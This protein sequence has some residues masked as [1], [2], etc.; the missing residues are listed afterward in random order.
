MNLKEYKKIRTPFVFLDE[1][2]SLN[3]KANRYFG[4]GM[5]K[6]MQPYYLD[7]ELRLLRQKNN[8]YDEIKW[9]TISKKKIPFIKKLIDIYF[10]IP[11]LKFSA[12]IINK[13]N[14]DFKTE[15]NNDTYVAY[16]KF[17]ESLLKNNLSKNEVLTV[18]ADYITTPNHIKFEV[19]TKHFLNKEFERLAIA[20][21]YRIDSHAVNLLQVTDLLLGAVIYDYKMRNKL[22]K[23]DPN[24]IQIMKL[25]LRKLEKK[26]FEQCYSSRTFK[27][28]DY[29]QI[30]K[31]GHHPNG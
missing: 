20:G 17:T 14:I 24:K 31:E 5:I 15:F 10:A 6:C 16:Q 25:I 22:V 28:M 18:L 9:N 3:D 8:F 12:V 27:I 7:H 19:D 11:G 29:T 1:T 26:T 23:G 30:K 2:G 13:D 21:I 4:L